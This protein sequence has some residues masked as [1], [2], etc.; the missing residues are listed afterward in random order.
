MQVEFKHGVFLV[1]VINLLF[2]SAMDEVSIE[3]RKTLC[4]NSTSRI[5]FQLKL[6]I[7]TIILQPVGTTSSASSAPLRGIQPAGTLRPT[8]CRPPSATPSS[9]SPKFSSR[10]PRMSLRTFSPVLSQRARPQTTR[11]S[12]LPASKL[13]KAVN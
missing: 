10:R 7:C 13:S 9:T 8:E 5:I 4:L 1:E 3:T 6:L 2:Y 12:I 11:T